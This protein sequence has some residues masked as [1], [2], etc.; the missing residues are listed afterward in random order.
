MHSKFFSILTL[1][2]GAIIVKLVKFQEEF[3]RIWQKDSIALRAISMMKTTIKI[4]GIV[5]K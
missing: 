5:S 2:F 3:T 4:L 1:V